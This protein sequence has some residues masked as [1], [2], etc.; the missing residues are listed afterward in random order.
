MK[1]KLFTDINI[2]RIDNFLNDHLEKTQNL[3]NDIPPISSVEI[4]INGACNR[5][6][7][8][9]PR[10]DED[11]YPNVLSNLDMI[12]F[13][14]LI[15]DLK[16]INFSGRISFSGFCEPLL[17]KNLN[18]YVNEIRTNLE[19]V[20][21]EVV[22]NGDPI[23][24]KGG[25]KR[26]MNLFSEGLDNCRVS[27]YDGEYQVEIFEKIKNELNLSNEQ[28]I[29]RKRYLGPD[30][31]F[32]LTISNRA[33]SVELKNEIFELKPLNEPLKQP[34]HYPL[35]KVL[36]DHDGSVLICSNDWKKELIMGNI[37][38]DSL[39]DI[40]SNEKF[41]DLR[42]KLCKSDRNHSPCNV[43]DV[44]GTLNGQKSFERWK[45]YFSKQS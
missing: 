13:K 30:E 28:F 8:F 35:Y 27:L 18:V 5:R 24:A 25:K 44:N 2:S 6:C 43:C 19:K 16:K 15:K 1:K 20:I 33:G 42:K 10:V 17:S 4:S 39:I 3:P 9:C 41:L 37:K 12:A 32:G 11:K 29:I 40:W 38:K 34:C 22:T 36:I 21:I 26:L 45:N 31:S 7:F 14:N 23:V